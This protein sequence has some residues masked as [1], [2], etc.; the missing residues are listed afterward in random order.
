MDFGY[1]RKIQTRFVRGTF[2]HFSNE[3][4]IYKSMRLCS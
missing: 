4:R 1:S 3:L 2:Y